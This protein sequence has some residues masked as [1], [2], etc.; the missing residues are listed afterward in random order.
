MKRLEDFFEEVY[1]K[2]F[3][4]EKFFEC[5][6]KDV[7]KHFE[8]FASD[9]LLDAE[10]EEDFSSDIMLEKFREEK[11]TEDD[12][13]KTLDY[14]YEILI[15]NNE[16]LLRNFATFVAKKVHPNY[17]SIEEIYEDSTEISTD[18]VEGDISEALQNYRDA[19]RES[20]EFNSY[21]GL[22]W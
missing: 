4:K 6:N 17:N 8:F 19:K 13:E 15:E 14:L 5:L 7:Q 22:N 20:K 9:Y 10:N 21:Y 3:K 1:S 2:K 11:V 12:L 18:S 16:S